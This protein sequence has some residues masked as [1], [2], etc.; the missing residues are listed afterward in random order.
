MPSEFTILQV[1]NNRANAEL[2]QQIMTRRV[3]LK[4]LTAANG[5]Q[6]IEMG[7]RLQPSLIL[8]DFMMPH[9]NGIE[10]LALLR[11]CSETSHIPVI[12]LSSNA[13]SGIQEKCMA[14]GAF[15]FLTKP[16]RINDLLASI[17]AGL[18]SVTAARSLVNPQ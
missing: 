3:D 14:A 8:M 16:Y 10:A 9:M 4:L 6:G 18:K 1:E 17:D 11:G 7:R 2:V 13:F 12:I 5:I 15:A